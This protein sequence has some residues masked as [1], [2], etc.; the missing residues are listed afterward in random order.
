MWRF[1]KHNSKYK[2]I[3]F[4]GT[5]TAKGLEINI[6]H[7]KM[8]IENEGKNKKFKTKVQQIT[9]SGEK[10]KKYGQEVI[11]ITER[12]VFK[13][14]E[15]GIYLTEAAP[16]IDIEKDIINQMDFKPFIDKNFKVM[17]EKIFL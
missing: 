4:C 17:D 6:R 3:I 7:G 2:K 5:F 1:Y 8:F 12:A 16:G 15:D 10:A 11:Y 14:K 9:F 13:L